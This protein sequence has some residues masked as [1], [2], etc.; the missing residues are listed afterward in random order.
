MKLAKLTTTAAIVL[1]LAMATAGVALADSH[2]GNIKVLHRVTVMRIMGGDI[3]A[4]AK[5][6]KGEAAYSPALIERAKRM[7]ALSQSVIVLFPGDAKGRRAKPEIWTDRATFE[8]AAGALGAA[9]PG[10][11]KAV[12]T[13]DRAQI[14]QALGAV[15]KSCGGCHKPFRKPKKK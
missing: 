15:G 10:L 8:K 12:E 9:T 7:E 1:G 11:V 14:G 2:G 13:G 6:A 4:I 5:V 3:G